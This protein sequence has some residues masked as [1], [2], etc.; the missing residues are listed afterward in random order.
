[1]TDARTGM[2]NADDDIR[3]G[4]TWTRHQDMVDKGGNYDRADYTM[5]R[6]ET[7]TSGQ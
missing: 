4:V 1:M 7:L 3:T 2:T 5:I 6:R